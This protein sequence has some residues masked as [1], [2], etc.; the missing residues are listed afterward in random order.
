M[1]EWTTHIS[2]HMYKGT[3]VKLAKKAQEVCKNDY[4][5]FLATAHIQHENNHIQVHEAY[6]KELNDKQE[7]YKAQIK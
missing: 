1:V 2:N 7:A 3:K 6:N 4:E 5:C